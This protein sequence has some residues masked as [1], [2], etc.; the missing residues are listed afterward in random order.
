TTVQ[1]VTADF[2][3]GDPIIGFVVQSGA[4]QPVLF[5]VTGLYYS[6]IAEAQSAQT[7]DPTAY[8]YNALVSPHI[9]NIATLGGLDAQKI[10]TA[11]TPM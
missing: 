10:A 8:R 3:G 4:A 9:G 2:L 5:G 6:T 7:N 1:K 11:A